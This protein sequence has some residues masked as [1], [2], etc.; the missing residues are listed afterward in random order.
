[1]YKNGKTCDKVFNTLF[2]IVKCNLDSNISSDSFSTFTHIDNFVFALI[3]NFAQFSSHA[4][5]EFFGSARVIHIN[6]S[7]VAI[8]SLGHRFALSQTQ[9]EHD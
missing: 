8:R 4:H 1:M 2:T 5:Y 7:R 9:N 6:D 3:Q